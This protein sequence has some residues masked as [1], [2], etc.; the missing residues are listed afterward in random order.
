[1]RVDR[2]VSRERSRLGFVPLTRP[3]TPGGLFWGQFLTARYD[4]NVAKVRHRRPGPSQNRQD[5]VFRMIPEP[6]GVQ[7]VVGSNPTVPTR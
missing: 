3:H 5:V 4:M 1:M 2:A 6:H 7:G